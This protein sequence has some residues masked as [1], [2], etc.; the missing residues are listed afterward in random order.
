MQAEVTLTFYDERGAEQRV[1]VAA[2]RFTIG[3]LPENDLA[4]EDSKLSRRH[5]VIENF[6]GRFLVSDCGSQNGTEVNRLPLTGAVEIHDGDVITLGG[7]REITVRIRDAA[8]QAEAQSNQIPSAAQNIPAAL[9]APYG[10]NVS[11]QQGSSAA[12]DSSSKLFSPPVIAV[13]CA[14]LIMIVAALIVIAYLRSGSQPNKNINVVNR[15]PPSNQN[16]GG[17]ENNLSNVG[18]SSNNAGDG[19][20]TGGDDGGA[21]AGVDELDEIER[22]ALRVMRSIS[23]DSNPTLSRKVLAEV[24]Q[25]IK[26]YQGSAVLRDQLRV[27]KQ[28]GVQ[29]LG[30]AAKAGNVKPPLVVYAALARMDRDNER[31]DPVQA[32]Q[33]MLPVLAHL[34]AIFGT[35]LANDSLLIV[36]AYDQ[37]PGGTTHPLQTTLIQLAKNQPESPATIRTVWYLRDHQRLSPQSYDLVL[38]F[39]AIGVV[40]QDP[41]KF[42][43]DAEPLGF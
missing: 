13:A 43:V 20:N 36:A 23:N 10:S 42:G 35:E 4:I 3:R 19:A 28:R 40:A 1:K 29:Q 6:D 12:Q 22:Y 9:F 24:N 33:R 14:V 16:E 25:K 39:L 21:N 37:G 2:R 8:A 7:S 17:S 31:G 30:P 5:A 27:M 15:R 34:R 41:H 18:N 26:G 32:A 38:R 11:T